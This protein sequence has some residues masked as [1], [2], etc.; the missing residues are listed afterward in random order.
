[1]ADQVDAIL[2]KYAGPKEPDA[3]DSILQKY[4]APQDQTQERYGN[5]EAGLQ[6]YGQALTLNHLPY[7]QAAAE[8]GVEKGLGFLGMGPDATDEKLKSQGFKIESPS[9]DQEK[10]EAF[11]RDQQI[12]QEHPLSYGSGQVTGI[13]NTLPIGSAVVG[14]LGKA[15]STVGNL[16]GIAPATGRLAQIGQAA[17][18]GG[19]M[20]AAQSPEGSENFLSPQDLE[21]RGKQGVAGA[22]VGGT[23]ESAAPLLKTGQKKLGELA[24]KY[25]LKSAGAMLRDMRNIYDKKTN[26]AISDTLF[27]NNLVSPGMNVDKIAK[28]SGELLNQ[29]GKEIG[30][31]YDK[32][33]DAEVKV[34]IP[35]LKQSLGE[36][37]EKSLPNIQRSSYLNAAENL[38]K[39]ILSQPEKLD[40]IRHLNNLIGDIDKEINWYAKAQ[41]SSN[42][43]DAGAF[44]KAYYAIRT[45]LR[46]TVNNIV[47]GTGK[48]SGDPELASR[49]KD[50]NKQY[51]SLATINRISNDRR[52]RDIANH[53]FG[54]IPSIVGGLGAASQV[55]TGHLPLESVAAGIATAGAI[56]G[57]Q[58]YGAPIAATAARKISQVPIP[59]IG[60]GSLGAAAGL[61]NPRQSVNKK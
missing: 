33:R 61:I 8:S 15:A 59:S 40:D 37:V 48:L 4:T 19:L 10:K 27:E 49:L 34:N 50:L 46:N 14:G 26:Q 2:Q 36:A 22:L 6:G 18:A 42:L 31:I 52:L 60:P 7:L 43:P 38:T 35:G 47:E 30:S 44:Q 17:A 41:Q 53:P 54:L 16:A 11:A 20:N 51:S 45:S 23:L 32:L 1:M 28:K 55:A 21:A 13:I 57:A 5:L 24:E 12:K 25:S 39:D 3:V 29:K 58:R 56:K 9:Y